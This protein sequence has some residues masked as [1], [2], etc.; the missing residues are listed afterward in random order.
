MNLFVKKNIVLVAVM[1]VSAVAGLVLLVFIAIASFGLFEAFSEINKVKDDVKTLNSKKPA[2]CPENEDRIKKDTAVIEQALEGFKHTFGLPMQ[3]A[4]DEFIK[5]LQPPRVA[6][7]EGEIG[8]TE[9]EFQEYR[10]PHPKEEEMD[11]E[12]R[13]KLP[14]IARK[15]TLAEFVKLYGSRF[16]REY[17]DNQS[18]D[19]LATQEF[20]ID[21]FSHLF[22]NWKA[23]LQAFVKVAKTLTVEPIADFNDESV[24]LTAMGFPRAIPH[25]AAFARQIVEYNDAL[26]KIAGNDEEKFLLA[27][28][29]L[30]FMSKT[31]A[32]YNAADVREIYF[33]RDVFG[34]LLTQVVKSGVTAMHNIKVR[35]FADS[36]EE[37]RAYG[38]LSESNGGFKFHHYTIEVSGTMESIRKLCSMLDET[39]TAKRLYVVRAVTLYAE[40]NG[41][42]ILMGQKVAPKEEDKKQDENRMR[43]RRRRRQAE[44]E[45]VSESDHEKWKQ[46]EEEME[47][48]KAPEKRK[49]Y[50]AV[51]IGKEPQCRAMIDIDYIIPEQQQ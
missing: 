11:D 2:P 38:S 32:K 14:R 16:E 42:A 27:P 51:L 41:A 8:L 31:G 43:G 37:G 3:S 5:V 40:E 39:H 28:A 50:A 13:Q 29:A 23:A 6:A 24:L 26:Q 15:L 20:F 22:P 49:D 18:K 19:M 36:L 17:G 35:D 44:E 25:S 21:R 34:H 48:A 12:A 46:V 9:E 33:H 45:E 10:Q 1:A 30:E 4:V 7:K 47:R